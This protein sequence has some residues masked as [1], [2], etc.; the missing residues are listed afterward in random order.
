[1]EY[2]SE[3]SARLDPICK[4]IA[5]SISSLV[6]ID[7][8]SSNEIDNI[9]KDAGKEIVACDKAT[10]CMIDVSHSIRD[11]I[12]PSIDENILELEQAFKLI[13]IIDETIIPSLHNDLIELENL[14]KF[15]YCIRILIAF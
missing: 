7:K 6:L 8:Q 11:N 15:T 3:I 9:L 1:M 14:G 5:T 4:E 12:M 10:N 13:D 2:K